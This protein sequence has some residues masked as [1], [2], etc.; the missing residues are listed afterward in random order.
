MQI[1]GNKPGLFMAKV[2]ITFKNLFMKR[3][4]VA[5]SSSFVSEKH[6]VWYNYNIFDNMRGKTSSCCGCHVN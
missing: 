4:M 2:N 3:D 1:R 6:H 5:N